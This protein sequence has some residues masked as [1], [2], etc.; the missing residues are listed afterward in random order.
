[1]K[2]TCFGLFYDAYP[3]PSRPAPVLITLLEYTHVV[4]Y[5][6]SQW[7]DSIGHSFVKC[8]LVDFFLAF[9]DEQ[10]NSLEDSVHAHPTTLQTRCICACSAVQNVLKLGGLLGVQSWRAHCWCVPER[11]QWSMAG[12]FAYFGKRLVFAQMGEKKQTGTASA[13]HLKP[14][15]YRDEVTLSRPSCTSWRWQW[16]W[17]WR[18]VGVELY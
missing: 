10:K 4:Y 7:E 16:P 13:A 12:Y 11:A 2:S 1:M 6:K 3:H 8:I 9:F 17:W 5:S 15:E 18:W 14:S